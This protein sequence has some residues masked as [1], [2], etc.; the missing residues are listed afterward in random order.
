[1]KRSS[2]SSAIQGRCTSLVSYRPARCDEPSATGGSSAALAPDA[3]KILL[4]EWL[5]GFPPTVADESSGLHISLGIGRALSRSLLVGDGKSC[6]EAS[7]GVKRPPLT[8]F[9]LLRKPRG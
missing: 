6:L 7:Y 1:M 4:W 2:R 3:A 9:A 8:L 5:I